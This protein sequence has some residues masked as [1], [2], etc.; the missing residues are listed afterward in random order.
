MGISIIIVGATSVADRR[1]ADMCSL[2]YMTKMTGKLLRT[3][4][5]AASRG[6]KANRTEM[7]ADQRQIMKWLLRMA[8]LAQSRTRLCPARL[9]RHRYSPHPRT[10]S[11]APPPGHCS[12]L[13]ACANYARR[14]AV[15]QVANVVETPLPMIIKKTLDVSQCTDA[16]RIARD[17]RIMK[18]N[19]VSLRLSQILVTLV[20]S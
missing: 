15:L 9:K 4:A 2:F 11:F 1:R 17:D 12:S 16:D 18:L 7:G 3:A 6:V 8:E 20:F 10:R 5:K 19:P 13:A 14:R